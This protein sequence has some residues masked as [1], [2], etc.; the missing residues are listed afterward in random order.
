M[1]ARPPIGPVGVSAVHESGER[2]VSGEAR[3]VD[4]IPAP[5][6]CLWAYV[7]CSEQA[8]GRLVGVDRSDAMAVDG[9]VAVLTAEDV[10]G[11]L[12]VGPIVHDEPLL[13]TGE[14]LCRGQAVALVVG[15]TLDACRRGAAALGVEVHA[16][17]PILGI[18]AAID[19]GS[20]HTDPHVI[21]RGDVAAAL[22]AADVVVEGEVYVP[23]QDHFYLETQAA[24]AVPGED[25]CLHIVS[26]TQHPTEV[27]AA[28]ARV[29]GRPRH[30]VTVET[31]RMGGAFGGKESQATQYAALAGLGA[32]ATGRPV[33]IWLERDQ[34]MILTG[35]R[36]PFLGRYRCGFDAAGRIV[37]FDAKIWSDGGWTADLSGPVLDRAM[38]HL[39]GAYAIDVLRFEGRVC[40]THVKSSTAFRGFGGPQGVVV[41][42]DAIT[43]Y[44]EQTGRDPGEV[45]LA[46]LYDDGR[47]VTPYGQR[48]TANRLPRISE[49]LMASSDYRARRAAI[50]QANAGDPHVKRG[51]GFQP[52][53]FGISFTASLL[54]QAGALVLV[55]ADGSVQLNH[56]GTEMGQGL[57]T[58]MLAVCA[59]ELGVPVGAVRIMPTATDK[60]PNTSATAASSGADLNGQAVAE[61]C[62]TVRERMR[63]VAARELGVD[64]G[65]IV[66]AEGRVGVAGG[67]DM[68]FS[69]L[70]QTCWAQQVSLSATGFY[71][72]PGI[73][74]DREAGRGTPFNYFAFGG[75]V[76]EVE[77]NG[78]TGEYRVLRADILHDVGASLVPSIDVGQVEGGFVQGM[79]WLTTEELVWSDAGA[80]LTHGPSTYKIPA[81]GDTPIDFRVAL[82]D[83]APQVGVIGGSKAV[84]E[85]PFLLAIG[86]VTALRHAIEGFRGGGVVELGLPATA[87]S[88][89]RAIEGHVPRERA[90]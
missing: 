13:A 74:Y 52:V 20:F 75:S 67:P 84:G 73:G 81:F 82:L 40:R 21:A 78:L 80:L 72:T 14:V 62:A 66:F 23:G 39:G 24:L 41:V 1:N 36:H 3:Y 61:A 15:R 54:N 77:V 19:A 88:V 4:D 12:T 34:D 26:S 76:V 27:Q 71:A 11:E 50:E 2:H 55:Y 87:E 58:K 85:P 30:A 51:V 56:G 42:E 18:E 7:A 68:A 44:A 10:P 28:T 69:D 9:V 83:D 89:L 43:R 59:Q 8:H 57:H 17:E 65:A 49:E 86:V 63:G 29:L 47:D 32:A 22:D 6:G 53:M 90:W 25:G 5:H 33:R 70:A 48:V 64:A 45:R 37:G 38:F 79:G 46:N 35:G 31:V 16:L 60:V